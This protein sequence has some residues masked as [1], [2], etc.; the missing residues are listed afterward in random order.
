VQEIASCSVI[1]PSSTISTAILSA[2]AAVR[3]PERVCSM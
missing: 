3:L 1:R 2:A